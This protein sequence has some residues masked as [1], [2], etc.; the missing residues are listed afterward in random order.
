MTQPTSD[1]IANC[2]LETLLQ[3]GK[4]RARLTWAL[5]DVL[6]AQKLRTHSFS[7]T[8]LDR[9]RFD[10]H[11]QHVLIEDVQ[12]RR[13]VCCFRLCVYPDGADVS[14]SYSAQYY[15]L[16]ALAAFKGPML[17]IGRFCI[18]KD[19]SDPDILRVAWAALTV[20]VDRENIKMLFGCTSFA[21]TETKTY[22]DVFAMLKHRYVAPKCWLPKIKSPDVYEYGARLRHKPDMRKAMLRMP[23]LLRTYLMMGGWVSDHAV[24]DRQLNTLHVFTGLE[25]EAIPATRKRLLRAVV[26]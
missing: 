26:G 12:S 13:L 19:W 10:E 24:V 14:Q 25:V 6:A 16:E 5:D 9:D 7:M 21:G 22:L 8:A 18:H 23:A 11:C 2:P 15:D 20:L 1:D 3:K 17:E 4:Y